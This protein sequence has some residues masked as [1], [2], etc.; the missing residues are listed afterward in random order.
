MNRSSRA[1]EPIERRSRGRRDYIRATGKGQSGRPK[2][3]REQPG[4]L[5]YRPARASVRRSPEYTPGWRRIAAPIA[6]RPRP[7]RCVAWA[8][9][10]QPSISATRRSPLPLWRAAVTAAICP[11]MAAHRSRLSE[12]RTGCLPDQSL[13]TGNPPHAASGQERARL[14]AP[15]RVRVARLA[16]G[17]P[18]RRTKA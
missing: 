11:P 9:T 6:G 15:D 18:V 10:L 13:R 14:R 17:I 7:R 5:L 12:L 1:D 2:A 16:G 8:T 4:T 3:G